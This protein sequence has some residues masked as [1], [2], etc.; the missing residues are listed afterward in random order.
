MQRPLERDEKMDGLFT[1]TRCSKQ[2]T[3]AAKVTLLKFMRS[4]SWVPYKVLVEGACFIASEHMKEE[5][6][7]QK[8]KVIAHIK[9]SSKKLEWVPAN[10]CLI[11]RFRPTLLYHIMSLP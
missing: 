9:I 1:W 10:V 11:S 5:R 7:A 6:E 3:S 8:M 2:S 4:L